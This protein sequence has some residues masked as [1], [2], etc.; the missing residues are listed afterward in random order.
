MEI[1]HLTELTIASAHKLLVEKKISSP[2]LVDACLNRTA[3]L[4]PKLHAFLLVTENQARKQAEAAQKLIDRGEATSP[5]LGIPMAHKDVYCTEG[6]PTTAA[7]NILKGYVPPY[8]AAAAEKLNKAGAVSLGK[9][10]CDA[11]AHGSSTENSDFG[12]THNPYDLSC[13]PGGSSGGSAAAVAASEV[14]FSTGTDT[15]GSIRHPSGFCNVVGLKPTYGR[16]SRFGIIAMASSTDSPGPIAKTV[17][18]C[19]YVL[20]VMAGHDF[21]DATASKRPVPDYV[22]FLGR[23]IKGWKVGVPKEFFGQGLDGRVEKLIREAIKQFESL[24]ARVEEMSMPSLPYS[25]AAYYIIMPSE[26]SSN[27]ARY[28]G[29]KY[30]FS[31]E[32]AAKA[33]PKDLLE[34][35][36]QSRGKGFGAEAKRR[37]MLGTYTLSSGYYDAYYKKA[38]AVRELIRQD[39]ARAFSKY[40]LLLSPV[41]PTPPF[42]LGEKAADPLAM[43]LS[44]IYTVSLNMAGSP[45]ISVPAGF[46]GDLPVGLQIFGAHFAEEKILQAAYAYEQA[47]QFYKIKPKIKN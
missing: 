20:S 40:D 21:R 2:E 22:S 13:V 35:Y 25:L 43:Y 41:S 18:D 37:I 10:N 1:T 9:L 17:E 8:S 14:I 34:V 38:Q 46:V 47:T 33:R 3:Q 27:L 28:D 24:G 6:V 15:G 30:G 31:V 4:E 12:P 7:S 29:I 45:G 19:A 39:F 36:E 32:R 26:V 11:F 16:V 5:L 44:D 23:D 42:K